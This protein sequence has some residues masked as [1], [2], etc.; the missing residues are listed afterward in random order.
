MSILLNGGADM[1]FKVTWKFH[2]LSI[3]MTIG[4][5]FLLQNCVINICT[6]L[7]INNMIYSFT[8][9]SFFDN[10]IFLSLI[11]IP[12]NIVHELLHGCV[13]RI[14]GGKLKYGFNGIYAYTLETTGIS[15]LRIKFLLV[16][17]APV[18]VISI[19]S[20]F[21][22]GVMGGLIFI[23]NL[24]GSTGDILMALYLCK[25][26]NNCY[27]IDRKYGFDVVNNSCDNNLKV[28]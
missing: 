26:N 21:I 25:F 5:Y 9:N 11:L 14:F 1:S 19:I 15:L 27:I 17:L 3:L 24:S 20:L 10:V 28:N 7:L 23:L 12:I 16:L 6:V 18:T 13:Y 2:L 4:I 22:P 8:G